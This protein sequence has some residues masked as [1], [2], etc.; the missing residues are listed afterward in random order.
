MQ[1]D[2]GL[3]RSRVSK[4]LGSQGLPRASRRGMDAWRDEGGVGASERGGPYRTTAVPVTAGS[5]VGRPPC[6]AELRSGHVP[7]AVQCLDLGLQRESARIKPSES[8]VYSGQPK[9]GP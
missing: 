8:P 3:P 5:G 6:Q 1:L 7:Q 4:A 9:S 2:Q